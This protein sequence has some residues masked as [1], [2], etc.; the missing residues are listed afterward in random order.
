[1]CFSKWS[2]IPCPIMFAWLLILPIFGQ[3]T[4][5]EYVYLGSTLIATETNSVTYSVSPV[6][7]TLGAAA[8][9]NHVFVYAIAGTAWSA[10]TSAS[11]V[12]LAGPTSGSGNGSVNFTFDANPSTTAIRYA[13]INFGPV[14]EY[15]T[16]LPSAV[17]QPLNNSFSANPISGTDSTF[18]FTF[19]SPGGAPYIN[20]F[21]SIINNH[22]GYDGACNFIYG[23]TEDVL[24]LANGQNGTWY[25]AGRHGD[26]TKVLSRQSRNV[27]IPAK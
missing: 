10:I 15:L 17:G 22:L 8:G 19:S 25:V 16:Q 9:S 20:W 13:T 27:L 4:T 24:T 26:P 2:W 14:Q 12:H 6:K 23:A 5:K 18:T 21:Q 11:W 3:Q 7:D 1:M